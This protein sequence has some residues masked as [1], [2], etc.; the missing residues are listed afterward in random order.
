MD[1]FEFVIATLAVFAGLI[2]CIIVYRNENRRKLRLQFREVLKSRVPS[3]DGLERELAR[4][5]G[6]ALETQNPRGLEGV[7][8]V[9]YL[10]DY[11]VDLDFKQKLYGFLL[12]Y[13]TERKL[14]LTSDAAQKIVRVM[15]I[16]KEQRVDLET[17]VHQFLD[18]LS[19][20]GGDIRSAR[21]FM[22]LRPQYLQDATVHFV[23]DVREVVKAVVEI[24]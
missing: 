9:P 18:D 23:E 3:S 21:T 5:I 11:I 15:D 7:T 2:G 10:E 4:K 17:D 1:Y 6:H 13:V 12:S 8:L 22:E 19:K 20:N 16:W 14:I 24:E